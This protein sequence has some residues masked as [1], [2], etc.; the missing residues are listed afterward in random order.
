MISVQTT[1]RGGPYD[2]QIY[3]AV[4][5]SIL[6]HIFALGD[7]RTEGKEKKNCYIKI[8]FFFVGNFFSLLMQ[9]GD[10]LEEGDDAVDR[11]E[12]VGP[13]DATQQQIFMAV[14][15]GTRCSVNFV[16]PRFLSQAS[17]L[18]HQCSI[19]VIFPPATFLE[20]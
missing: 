17:P 4:A 18:R 7:L 11:A 20:Q 5:T 2:R 19:F 12:Q 10:G 8:L 9:T 16:L 14:A 3:Q 13:E 1:Y 15:I 6:S